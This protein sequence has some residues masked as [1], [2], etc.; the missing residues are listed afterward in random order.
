MSHESDEDEEHSA[1][2]NPVNFRDIA[3]TEE[4]QQDAERDDGD[5]QG[6]RDELRHPCGLPPGRNVS[7]GI[8][9]GLGSVLWGVV[10][11]A[12]KIFA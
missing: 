4:H 1:G 2:A 12:R 8:D 9:A 6:V 7:E 5:E 3:W 10:L 11:R